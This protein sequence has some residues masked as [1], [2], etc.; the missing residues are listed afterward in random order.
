MLHREE[1]ILESECEM[2]V[3]HGLLSKIPDD[4]PF[5]TLITRAYNLYQRYSPDEL[6]H[7]AILNFKRQ[8]RLV[9]NLF[10]LTDLAK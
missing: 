2:C 6:A 7:E 5:E 9:L 10:F 8:Q 4:L 1:E 3:I